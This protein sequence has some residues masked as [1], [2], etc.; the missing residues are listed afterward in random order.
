[1]SRVTK[2]NYITVNSPV[3]DF[4]ATPTYGKAPLTVNFTDNST[5]LQTYWLWTF[6]DGTSS[7]LQN[8]V[9]KYAKYGNYT[10]TL[11][12][13]SGAAMSKVT[14][15]NYITVISPP[16]ASFYATPIAGKAP[17]TVKFKDTSTGLPN[18]WYWDFGDGSNSTQQYPTHN[19][20]VGGYR[21]YCTV[22]LTVQNEAGNNTK[23]IYNYIRVNN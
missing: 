2:T 7:K 14:K 6:G 19:Y 18:S 1:M 23:K 12:V 15:T 17:L 10:V 20:T 5:G 21:K 13:W 3:A 4:Y 16:V 11:R 9:H 22:T 8:P